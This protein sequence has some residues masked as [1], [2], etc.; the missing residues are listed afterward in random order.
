[1]T[2]ITL[3]KLGVIAMCVATVPLSLAQTPRIG[4]SGSKQPGATQTGTNLRS[5]TSTAPNT[6]AGAH[7]GTAAATPTNV[8][9][10]PRQFIL[11]PTPLGSNFSTAGESPSS[12]PSA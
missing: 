10:V 3:I 1:M 12:L 4:A 7:T 11:S 2:Q 8:N 9:I 5:G 6:N